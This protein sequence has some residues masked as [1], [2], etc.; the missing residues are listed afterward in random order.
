MQRPHSNQR[1]LSQIE[2]LLAVLIVSLLSMALLSA[3]QLSVASSVQTRVQ[4]AG[5]QL[6]QMAFAKLRNIDFYQVFPCDSSLP[7][8]GLRGDYPNLA[9]LNQLRAKALQL[10]FSKFT[11]E[12]TFMRRDSSDANGNGLTSDLIPF[13]DDGT[14]VDRYDPNIRYFDQNGEGDYYDTYFVGGRR[15]SE[16][17]DTHIKLVTFK[18]WKGNRVA[19]Q[20]AQLMSLEGFSGTESPSSESSLTLTLNTPSNN[21]SL[22]DLTTSTRNNAFNLVITR[23][24]PPSAVAYRADSASP[25]QLTGT[26]EPSATVRFYVGVTTGTEVASVGT[27]ISGNFSLT[28]AAITARLVEGRNRLFARTFK[29]SLTSPF[30]PRDVILDLAPPLISSAAPPSPTKTLSPYVAGILVD[31]PT[32]SGPEVSGITVDVIAF[33]LDGAVAGSR[34][35]PNSGYVTLLDSTTL[36]PPVLSTGT[37]TVTLEGGDGAHYKVSKTWG[38][39]VAIDTYDVTA[40]VIDQQTPVGSTPSTLPVIGARLSDPES[41]INLASLTMTVDGVS[42]TNPGQY[43]NLA[44]GAIQYQPPA[45]FANG[46]S[47]TIVV[48]VSHWASAPPDQMTKTSTW[49]FTVNAP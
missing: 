23:P 32:V 47:H 48:T 43:Y 17:P 44:T 5:A 26:T 18:L 36:L 40:P 21:A 1:G 12:L 11:I 19:F 49:G 39:Q 3:L 15:V 13:S 46:S 25:L 28:S 29:G 27:D 38:F 4:S 30:A 14:G 16:M 6:L 45:P 42:L 37:H 9:T 33:K 41:G 10:G 8:F 2:L 31:S 20:D 34:Y 24:Y 22:Y 7:G 35:D